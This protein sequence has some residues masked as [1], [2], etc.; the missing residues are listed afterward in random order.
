[1][2]GILLY[3]VNDNNVDKIKKAFKN[4]SSIKLSTGKPGSP[5]P[6]KGILERKDLVIFDITTLDINNRKNIKSLSTDT[7]SFHGSGLGIIFIL[8][9]DQLKI[10]FNNGTIADGFILSSQIEAEL[11]PRVNFLLLKMKVLIPKDSLVVGDM[12]LN[13]E[14]YE[15]KVNGKIV[16]LTFKEF[17]MLKLLLQNQDKVFTRINLLSTV[18]GYDYYGGSRTVDVHMRRLRAKIPPPYNNMLKTIRNVG[19]MFSPQK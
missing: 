8:N 5:V 14:K 2:V 6:D 17:E 15:L 11:I 3:S 7:S 10:L 12:I 18:W 16:V 13:F 1:M 9:P 19:Y 4:E